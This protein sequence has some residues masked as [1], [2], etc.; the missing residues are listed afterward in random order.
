VNIAAKIEGLAE[1]GSVCIS[2]SVFDQVKVKLN[3]GYKY[4]IIKK[5]DIYEKSRK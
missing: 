2:R 3:F 5:R 4:F 1:P